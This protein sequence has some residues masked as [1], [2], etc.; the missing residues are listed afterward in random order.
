[1]KTCHLELNKSNTNGFVVVLIKDRRIVFQK[2][3]IKHKYFT[4]YAR[5]FLNMHQ[6]C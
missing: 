4:N 5:S 3:E 2:W 6:I 1:M